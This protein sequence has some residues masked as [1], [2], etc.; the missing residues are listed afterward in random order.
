MRE[1]LTQSTPATEL[2]RVGRYEVLFDLHEDGFVSRVAARVRGPSAGPRLIELAKVDHSLAVEAEV[3]A[4]FL[5]EA[6]AAGRVHHVHFVQPVDSLSLDGDLFVATELTLG[7]RLDE[8]WRA[9]REQQFAIPLAV[10]LR[11]L[12]DVLAGVSALHAA[13][14]GGASA[15]PLVHGD[16]CPANIAISFRGDARLVHSGLGS[17]ASRVGPSGRRNARLAY[18]APEQLRVGVNAVPIGPG[19][20]VFA[21][22]VLLWEAL[23]GESPFD[24]PSDVDIVERICFG[25]LPMLDPSESRFTH[26][27]LAPLVRAALERNPESRIPDA[28]ELGDAIERTHGVRAGA[29]EE[30]ALA[31]DRLLGPIVEQR[32]EQIN[33]ALDRIEQQRTVSERTILGADSNVRGARS[34]RTPTGFMVARP[35]LQG[36]PGTP[37]PPSVPPSA[38]NNIPASHTM[39]VPSTMPPR[40][41]IPMMGAPP[42]TFGGEAMESPSLRS[43]RRQGMKVVGWAYAMGFAVVVLAVVWMWKLDREPPPAEVTGSLPTN[44]A[45]TPVALDREPSTA[46]PLVPPVPV[47]AATSLVAAPSPAPVSPVPIATAPSLAPGPLVTTTAI[48][49]P[50]G[51]PL[52]RAPTPASPAVVPSAS[53]ALPV[54]KL[55]PVALAHPPAPARPAS[56]PP[57]AK[58]A[59]KPTAHPNS[60]IIPEDI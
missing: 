45:N 26:L 23:K 27:A 59:P 17:A 55:P 60:D 58:P 40:A 10:N 21:V 6:R 31:V 39:R 48:A 8:L 28:G 36:D 12:L 4:A 7:V 41:S 46:M 57:V 37:R 49:A 11:I 34:V 24:A 16:I 44:A 33:E 30:V 53:A 42:S 18:K 5:S 32:R 47:P 15:R 51:A 56:P 50:S 20:D 54:S 2:P 1:P 13:A 29:M 19:A 38:A 43:S 35:V 22:G 25:A 52:G 9:A 14:A 3:R